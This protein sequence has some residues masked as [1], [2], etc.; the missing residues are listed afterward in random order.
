MAVEEDVAGLDVAVDHALF[1]VQVIHRL[2]HLRHRTVHVSERAGGRSGREGERERGREG[3]RE[4]GIEGERE[5][6]RE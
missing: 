4:I 3:E 5:R 1:F 6:G 2:Q